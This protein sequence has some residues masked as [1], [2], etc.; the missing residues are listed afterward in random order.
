MQWANAFCAQAHVTFGKDNRCIGYRPWAVGDSAQIVPSI[1]ACAEDGPDT[2]LPSVRH[3]SLLKR[4]LISDDM[5]RPIFDSLDTMGS[6]TLTKDQF[7][8]WLH[9]EIAESTDWSEDEVDAFFLTINTKNDG[10]ITCDDLAN[11]LRVASLSGGV[12]I[13]ALGTR[14]RV[15]SRLEKERILSAGFKAALLGKSTA[16]C[17]APTC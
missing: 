3:G 4:L 13:Y 15:F 2:R 1:E 9:A 14:G 12:D 10:V 11:A 6:G 5:V 7:Y 17:V 16:P 8:K